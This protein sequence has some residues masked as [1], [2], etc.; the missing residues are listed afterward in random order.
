MTISAMKREMIDK[1]L[2]NDVYMPKSG[3]IQS[4]VVALSKLTTTELEQL[5]LV[6]EIKSNY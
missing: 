2:E 4:L 6:V 5:K 3:V 1:I